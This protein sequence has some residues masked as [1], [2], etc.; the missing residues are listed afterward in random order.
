MKP[1][2]LWSDAL[3]W[4]LVFAL[5]VFFYRLRKDPQTRER[6]GEVFSSRLGMVAFTV[7]VTYIGVALLDSMHF[8]KALDELRILT[9]PRCFTT[10][11]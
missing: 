3:I 9:A 7:I 1:V 8:R 2:I 6:W 11:R 5:V 4:L 10:P